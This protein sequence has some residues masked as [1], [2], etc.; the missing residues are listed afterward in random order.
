MPH[1]ALRVIT[2][3]TLSPLHVITNTYEHYVL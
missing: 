1:W 3:V 2:D